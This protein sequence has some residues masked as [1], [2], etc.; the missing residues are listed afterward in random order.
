MR[1]LLKFLILPPTVL[2]LGMGVGF[3]LHHRRHRAGLP[4]VMG[5][6]G[7]LVVLSL[8]V[9]TTLLMG[10][11]Q[12]GVEPFDPADRSHPGPQAIVILAAGLDEMA[13]EYGG[14]STVDDMTLLRL[15]YGARL[16]RETHLPILVTGGPWGKRRAILGDAMAR[17]LET[18]FLV[19]TR[20]VERQAGTSREN[21]EGSAEILLGEGIDTVLLV[22]HAWHM[23]RAKRAFE[24]AGLTVIP[25][26][27]AFERSAGFRFRSLLPS[28]RALHTNYYALHELIG[29]AWYALTG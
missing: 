11:A 9:T 29:R 19:K 13:P 3:L 26:P 24:R 2:Y 15:R 10:L 16:H 21:A 4:L 6:F 12:W 7:M 27:T 8:S 1:D 18:D 23:P 22:T 28:T 5:A 17:S 25:A 20:W 14:I